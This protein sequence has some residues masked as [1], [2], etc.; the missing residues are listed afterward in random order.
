M[1]DLESDSELD[2]LLDGMRAGADLMEKNKKTKTRRVKER[3][4]SDSD[5]VIKFNET[6]GEKRRKKKKESELYEVDAVT[7]KAKVDSRTGKFI[8]NKNRPA[9][10]EHYSTGES[11]Y[12]DEELY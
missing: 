10:K 1:I 2:V 3:E 11:S 7:G 9:R 5:Y 4:N 6:T 12:A 8:R